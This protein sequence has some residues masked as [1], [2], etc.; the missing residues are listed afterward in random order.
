MI[1]KNELLMHFPDALRLE[2]DVMKFKIEVPKHKYYYY[3]RLASTDTNN[4]DLLVTSVDIED[5]D[6]AIRSIFSIPHE[7]QQINLSIETIDKNEYNF[8][9]ILIVPNKFHH[10]LEG[11]ISTRDDLVLCVPIHKSEFSGKETVKEFATLQRMIP[12]ESWSRTVHPRIILRFDNQKTKGGTIGG[13]YVFCRYSTIMNEIKN[14]DGVTNGFIEI[15]NY[16]DNVLEI[17]SKNIGTYVLIRERDDYSSV[18]MGYDE[19]LGIVW[20]F[21]TQ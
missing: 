13:K 11:A 17:L 19:L 21:L 15:I 7:F 1:D 10:H 14:L 6:F 18:L 20:S 5:D 4:C 8:S 2:D 16:K 9:N 3:L 12:I